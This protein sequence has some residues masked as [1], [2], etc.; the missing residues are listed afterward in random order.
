MRTPLCLVLPLLIGASL[1]FSPPAAAQRRALP[2][3]QRVVLDKGIAA[4]QA[5]DLPAAMQLL[6]DAYRQSPRTEVLYHL[7]RLAAA[8][9][10]PLD[11]YDL[12]RRYQADPAY[13][14]DPATARVIETIA[15]QPLPPSG[16]LLV[17]SD[18]GALVFVDNRPVG[19]LPLLLPLL[20]SP[21][22]HT[23]KL[24]FPGKKM[25]APVQ[26]EVSRLTEVRLSRTSG[27]V[28][29]SVLPSI[30]WVAS[31]SGLPADVG[32]KLTEPVEQAVHDEQYTLLTADPV[33]SQRDELA[34]CLAKDSCPRALMTRYK[35]ELLLHQVIQVQ[36]ATGNP[37]WKFELRLVRLGIDKPAAAVA[38][39][40]DG[41]SV[42]QAAARLKEA[43]AKLLT[44]GLSRPRGTLQV[45]A[46]P[47]AVTVRLGER[48]ISPLPYSG[49]LWAGTYEVTATHP[50]Y[51]PAREQ[52]EVKD[53]KPTELHL[54]LQRTELASPEPKVPTDKR[55]TGRAPRPRWRLALG[56]S[57]L[58]VGLALTI[59]GVT[60]IASDNT[61]AVLTVSEPCPKVYNTLAVGSVALGGGLLSMGAGA[62]LL[63][64]PG[65]RR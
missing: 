2:R 53:G 40:C 25:E 14:V 62:V 34:R 19:T 49:T 47:A 15:N 64:L 36:K 65:P 21:G 41:C 57:L 29:V 23:V 24:E 38:M 26:T 27:A 16:S 61:C 51:Q 46:E 37:T 20:V 45:T 22:T 11:A 44:D 50:G 28:L 17:L 13:Q 8:E 54:Q 7:G 56:G 33:L 59:A 12:M 63:V 4:L 1:V 10:R 58:G 9:A 55:P 43:M 60:G 39:S 32:Q 52:V 18:A 5:H 3:E 6:T 42:P 35:T 31:A 48:A 30:L